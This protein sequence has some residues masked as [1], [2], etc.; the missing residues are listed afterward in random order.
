MGFKRYWSLKEIRREC[1]SN[2][3]SNVRHRTG[4]LLLSQ[5][6]TMDPAK[7]LNGLFCSRVIF[8]AMVIC[9]LWAQAQQITNNFYAAQRLIAGG[10]GLVYSADLNRDGKP[11]LVVLA[12]GVPTIGQVTAEVWINKGN[13]VFTQSQQILVNS[14]TTL[15]VADVNADGIP[16]LIY[17]DPARNDVLDVAFGT[18]QGTFTAPAGYTGP[19]A[20]ATQSP[21][22]VADFNGDGKP[23]IAWSRNGLQNGASQV[24]IFLNNGSGVFRS[25]GSLLAG[26]EPS[27]LETGD[28]NGD[29]I[30]DLVVNN[31]DFS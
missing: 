29:G 9:P 13:L 2:Q 4:L 24:V 25:G 23:D 22:I 3:A 27:A 1:R 30:Q 16:D 10:A 28:L 14:T 17:G 18:G 19:N 20:A 7:V 12:F 8:A 31:T 21:V 15:A 6:E 5:G 26:A 11:D